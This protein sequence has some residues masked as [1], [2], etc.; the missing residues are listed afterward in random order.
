MPNKL[1]IDQLQ[2][3]TLH[4]NINE[5][6]IVTKNILKIIQ[7]KGCVAKEDKSIFLFIRWSSINKNWVVDQ[8]TDLKRDI[9]GIT[10]ENL[11]LYFKKDT[12]LYSATNKILNAVCNN[13]LL[14]KFAQE[15]QLIK[16][17]TKILMFEY[18]IDNNVYPYGIFQL[19]KTKK[20]KGHE[21]NSFFLRCIDNSEVIKKKIVDCSKFFNLKT[22]YKIKNYSEVNNQF[23]NYLNKKIYTFSN[24]EVLDFEKILKNKYFKLSPVTE[25]S[26]VKESISKGNIE[27]Y[28]KEK[29]IFINSLMSLYFGEFLLDYLKVP[30][31][32]KILIWDIEKAVYIKILSYYFFTK[33]KND[34]LKKEEKVSYNSINLLPGV[35]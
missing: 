35:I 27:Y 10:K 19:S 12:L 6:F 14:F 2:Q 4:K 26:K 17:E 5:F 8:C 11:H 21:S 33:T 29:N 16:N 31:E 9:L 30:L 22:N 7:K 15:R 1:R 32:N 20:R 24:D 23:K 18:T 13:Q 28:N 34:Q 25:I 3:L